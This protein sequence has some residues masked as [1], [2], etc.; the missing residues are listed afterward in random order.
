[1][2]TATDI[3]KLGLKGLK[4]IPQAEFVSTEILGLDYI[5]GGGFVLQTYVEIFGDQNLGKSTLCLHLADVM[6]RR[7]EENQ[8][9]YFDVENSVWDTTVRDFVDQYDNERFL[10]AS[11]GRLQE[12]FDKI[13]FVVKNEDGFAGLI[14]ID[15]IASVITQNAEERLYGSKHEV[16]AKAPG[17]DVSYALGRYARFFTEEIRGEK[18][19]GILTNQERDRLDAYATTTPRPGGTAIKFTVSH[20][21]RLCG[22]NKPQADESAILAK[23]MGSDFTDGE[24]HALPITTITTEKSRFCRAR[25]SAKMAIYKGKIEPVYSMYDLL[26][27]GALKDVVIKSEGKGQGARYTLPEELELQ[28]VVLKGKKLNV[29]E[30]LLEDYYK[31]NRVSYNK[32]YKY[33]REK[34]ILETWKPEKLAE[35]QN[36]ILPQ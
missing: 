28:D 30:Y 10:L 2:I 34:Y 31:S 29:Y 4:E 16:E 25:R 3:K 32:L 20:C 33:V 6:I 26:M 24:E 15:S 8:V 13:K 21:V 11:T 23:V 9:I 14:V 12:I 36:L 5:T 1:M 18:V 7:N 19:L 17:S 22:T 35:S 27:E